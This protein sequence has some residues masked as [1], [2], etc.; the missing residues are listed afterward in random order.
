MAEDHQYDLAMVDDVLR[1][2]EIWKTDE[3]F[4]R[5]V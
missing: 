3:E 4:T 1:V 2:K 5:Q